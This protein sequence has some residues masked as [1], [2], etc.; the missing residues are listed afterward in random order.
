V[1]ELASDPTSLERIYPNLP[2]NSV[3]FAVMEPVSHGLASAHVV[4]VRLPIEW[5]DVGGYV[6]LA[7]HLPQQDGN[8]VEG[9][10][11]AL[12]STGNVIV[13][14]G[15][16]GALVAVVGLSDTI[17]VTAGGVTLVCPKD[18]AE[19]VKKLVASVRQT[20]GDTYA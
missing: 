17:V 11:V 4:A 8:A 16:D 1:M 13:N 2:K 12:D 15:G 9:R 3:D 19:D 14:R 7:E 10:V 6:A 20:V 5:Y 18:R